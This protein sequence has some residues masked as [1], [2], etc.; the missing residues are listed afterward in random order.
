M[1]KYTILTYW[2]L[3]YFDWEVM[4]CMQSNFLKLLYLSVSEP[5]AKK[6]LL[7]GAAWH[8]HGDTMVPLSRHNHTTQPKWGR[9][10]IWS[11][12]SF[13]SKPQVFSTEKF[14]PPPLHFLWKMSLEKTLLLARSSLYPGKSV[15][16]RMCRREPGPGFNWPNL[17]STLCPQFQLM[18]GATGNVWHQLDTGPS[19]PTKV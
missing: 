18:S 8:P 6:L 1:S 2:Q 5:A 4:L 14:C 13:F 7:T 15:Q 10:G 12:S 19:R 9:R 11:I 16:R 3:R 17:Q